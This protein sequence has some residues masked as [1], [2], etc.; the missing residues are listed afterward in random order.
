[1]PLFKYVNITMSL[2]PVVVAAS[3]LEA[4]IDDLERKLSNTEFTTLE[5]V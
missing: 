4:K 5:Q 1:M 3:S 2:V